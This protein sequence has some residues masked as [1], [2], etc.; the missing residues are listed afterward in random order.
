MKSIKQPIFFQAQTLSYL[1]LFEGQFHAWNMYNWPQSGREVGEGKATE[2]KEGTVWRVT[3]I[4][5]YKLLAGATTGPQGE[6]I[7]YFL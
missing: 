5:D 7:S 2:V 3:I 4:E 1:Q 6:E